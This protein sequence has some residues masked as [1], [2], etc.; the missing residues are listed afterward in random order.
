[1]FMGGVIVGN[2]VD[3]EFGGALLINQFEKGEPFL[4]TVARREATDRGLM[5]RGGRWAQPL[6]N[7]K[8]R[9]TL[10]WRK[11]RIQNTGRRRNRYWREGL[12]TS[13]R[14]IQI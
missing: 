6:R 7:R 10:C 5:C 4:M 8:F 9:P 11:G 14:R 2:D 12:C 13:V 3:V 1:M